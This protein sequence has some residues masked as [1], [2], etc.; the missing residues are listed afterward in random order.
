MNGTFYV[1]EGATYDLYTVGGILYVTGL[2]TRVT[3]RSEDNRV[4][5]TG[6][7]RTQSARSLSN[8]PIRLTGR[9][10]VLTLDTGEGL[11]D[12]R[13]VFV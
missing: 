8:S 5:L 12:L 9:R 10:A 3:Y 1:D 7:A 13:G 2:N 6:K 11:D 4:R